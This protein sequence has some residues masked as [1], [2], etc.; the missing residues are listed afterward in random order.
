MLTIMAMILLCSV[1]K[2]EAATESN[3]RL[4]S[5][6]TI[7][8]TEATS[9]KATSYSDRNRINIDVPV[10]AR[11]TLNR[12]NEEEEE[13]THHNDGKKRERYLASRR[14]ISSTMFSEDGIV[15]PSPSPEPVTLNSSIVADSRAQIAPDGQAI[16]QDASGLG[17]AN[18]VNTPLWLFAAAVGAG[19]MAIVFSIALLSSSVQRVTKRRGQSESED[20]AVI[21]NIT[22]FRGNE[23]VDHSTTDAASVADRSAFAS[24]AHSEATAK[25]RN[26]ASKISGSTKSRSRR[27]RRE[28]GNRNSNKRKT[29]EAIAE[30]GECEAEGA[31]EKAEKASEEVEIPV[32]S[33][34][35]GKEKEKDTIIDRL[36]TGLVGGIIAEEDEAVVASASVA[37]AALSDSLGV[38]PDSTKVEV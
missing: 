31:E 12:R 32:S 11:D 23:L 38:V 27:E 4:R 14:E 35:T 29:L 18:I 17:N 10:S 13:S 30:E 6:R 2:N 33:S 7:E 26:L 19:I 21:R 28:R 1:V 24:V 9:I 22:V 20:D 25:V 16:Q 5:T 15:T 34:A 8:I 36:W 37:G 3:T